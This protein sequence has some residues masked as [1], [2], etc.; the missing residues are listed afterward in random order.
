[1][2]HQRYTIKV[3]CKEDERTLARY[4]WSDVDG[5]WVRSDR[6]GSEKDWFIRVL[7]D[8]ILQEYPRPVLECPCG[9]SPVYTHD[10]LQEK[11]ADA[12]RKGERLL[13]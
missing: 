13:V 2:A 7:D 3:F 4:S 12:V 10:E 9:N 5:V 6:H 8:G 11:I 1:M